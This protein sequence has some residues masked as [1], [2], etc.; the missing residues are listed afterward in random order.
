MLVK[1]FLD[2]QAI[3]LSQT[4]VTMALNHSAES[5]KYAGSRQLVVHGEGEKPCSI[6]DLKAPFQQA[7][8]LTPDVLICVV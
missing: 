2:V 4:E 7:L 8:S 1:Y 3:L 6:P 5:E